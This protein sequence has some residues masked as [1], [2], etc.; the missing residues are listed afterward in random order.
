MH[1]DEKAECMT[2][3]SLKIK[4]ENAGTDRDRTDDLLDA[5]YIQAYLCASSNGRQCLLVID[6]LKL[7]VHDRQKNENFLNHGRKRKIELRL[8]PAKPQGNIAR[9]PFSPA[10]YD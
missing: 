2:Y 8:P 9:Y 3:N 6:N 7:G 4:R 1:E 10:D 5:I